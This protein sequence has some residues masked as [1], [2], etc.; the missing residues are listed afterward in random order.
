MK[1]SAVLI[2]KEKEYP[3]E[4]LESVL[5]FDEILIITE[6]PNILKRYETALKARNEIIYVQDDDCIIDVSKLFNQYNGQ[7]TNS[8][9][10]HHKDFYVKMGM[11]LVG[12]G[13][14]FP[15][16]MINFDRYVNKW[17]VDKLL[18]SQADR[19]FTY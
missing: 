6:C 11:T 17:G 14:F 9:T 2:S 7:I 13:C 16:K 4:V 3:Q 19:V 18:L 8:I 12:F 10:Q 5:G 1:V 15:K